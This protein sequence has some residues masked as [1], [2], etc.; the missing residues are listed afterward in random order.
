[1][2]VHCLG[3]GLL[4]AAAAGFVVLS[5]LG[6]SRAQDKKDGGLKVN[7][8]QPA[9]DVELPAA[10]VQKPLKLKDYQGKK[11]VV[12]FFYPKAATRG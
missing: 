2:R 10:N 11:H 9:P 3:R 1:M 8:G 5:G 7:E 12:L 6:D 4:V